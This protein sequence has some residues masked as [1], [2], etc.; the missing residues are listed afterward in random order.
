MTTKLNFLRDINGYNTFLL[1]P[2]TNVFNATL[3][4]GG[5]ETTCSIPAGF[6]TWAVLFSYED[7]V[8]VWVAINATASAPAGATLAAANSVLRP[9]GYALSA[10]DVIHMITPDSSAGVSVVMYGVS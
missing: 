5:G 8:R 3:T 9:V 7:S 4:S 1:S 6:N 2:S 10:G